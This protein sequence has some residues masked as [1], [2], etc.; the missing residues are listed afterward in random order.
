[1]N[2]KRTTEIKHPVVIDTDS[3]MTLSVQTVEP[4]IDH[5]KIKTL[6]P[7]RFCL[8]LEGELYS[9]DGQMETFTE[10]VLLDRTGATQL[11]E[12]LEKFISTPF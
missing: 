6:C 4:Y 12:E 7:K 10:P 11:L 3:E 1:M 5:G 2:T 9:E 8:L